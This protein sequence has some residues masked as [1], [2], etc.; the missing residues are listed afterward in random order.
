MFI[1]ILFSLKADVATLYALACQELKRKK[2]SESL[3]TNKVFFVFKWLIASRNPGQHQ[4]PVYW[5][6]ATI[7]H[8]FCTDCLDWAW[9]PWGQL[10]HD[11]GWLELSRI[12]LPTV[13]CWSQ[14]IEN[15]IELGT[16]PIYQSSH[17]PD[18]HNHL[19]T[20]S[21]H[22]NFLLK[23]FFSKAAISAIL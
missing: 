19:I 12:K 8:Y 13:R 20:L 22:E 17:Q 5:E 16:Q 14:I 21:I 7:L 3:I 18:N 11:V 4:H 2:T 6:S 15:K 23:Y 10:S 1:L 9:L